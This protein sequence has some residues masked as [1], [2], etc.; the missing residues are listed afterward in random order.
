MQHRAAFVFL[1]I[2]LNPVH[3]QTLKASYN[4]DFSHPQELGYSD[5]RGYSFEPAEAVTGVEHKGK[6]FVTADGP[7]FS[8]RLC[9]RRIT[10]PPQRFR[11][12]A[13]AG[14]NDPAMQECLVA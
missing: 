8:Q 14:N 12:M 1:V 11:A 3:A 7:S 2:V 5:D 6:G 9:P 13:S 4:V 10:A